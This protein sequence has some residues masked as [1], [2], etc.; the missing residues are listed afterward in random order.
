MALCSRERGRGSALVLPFPPTGSLLCQGRRRV[1][2]N[3]ADEARDSFT[4]SPRPRS[5]VN[6]RGKYSLAGEQARRPCS[7]RVQ[8]KMRISQSCERRG[9]R[10]GRARERAAK[11]SVSTGAPLQHER[12]L[13]PATGP[14]LRWRVSAPPSPPTGSRPPHCRTCIML[15]SPAQTRL[16]PP[17]AC[18]TCAASS[19]F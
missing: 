3:Q 2:W 17:K 8:S 7:R 12:M 4:S 14:F 9:R 13:L 10:Q 16:L 18:G 15:P 6:R 5:A 19:L 1:R 11:R